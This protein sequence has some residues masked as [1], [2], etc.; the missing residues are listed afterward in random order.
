ML[1]KPDD[2][3]KLDDLLA[4]L[5]QRGPLNWEGKGQGGW[6]RGS[7]K[8]DF[9]RRY[10]DGRRWHGGHFQHLRKSEGITHS[11][12]SGSSK[13]KLGH[14]IKYLCILWQMY[15]DPVRKQKN[16]LFPNELVSVW[17]I[18]SLKI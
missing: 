16:K 2:L 1:L 12:L 13:L 5:F 15:V 6:I 4:G 11:H 18:K 10:H 17:W 14:L 8:Q 9:P 3:F 7:Q